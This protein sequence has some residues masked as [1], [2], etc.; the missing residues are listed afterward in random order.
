M[1]LSVVYDDKLALYN[2]TDLIMYAISK[3]LIQTPGRI[4]Q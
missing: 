4:E 1:G 2:R 3:G